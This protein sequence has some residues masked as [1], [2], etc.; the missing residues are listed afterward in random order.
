[1]LKSL[2]IDIR[3]HLSSFISVSLDVNKACYLYGRKAI[4]SGGAT[5]NIVPIPVLNHIHEHHGG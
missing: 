3:G 1:M 2:E 5:M 4:K